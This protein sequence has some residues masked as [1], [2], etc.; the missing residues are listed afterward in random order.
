[1]HP[2][3]VHEE[4]EQQ[5]KS[6][7][8]FHKNFSFIVGAFPQ[9]ISSYERGSVACPPDSFAIRCVHA[10]LHVFYSMVG[11]QTVVTDLNYF[12][13]VARWHLNIILMELPSVFEGFEIRMECPMV[14]GVVCLT[15]YTQVK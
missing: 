12:G 8:A 2:F 6:K 3:I 14:I 15:I 13:S 9:Y 5:G 1:M 7:K 4:H 11:F 10:K